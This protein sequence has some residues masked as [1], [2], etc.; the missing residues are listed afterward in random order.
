MSIGDFFRV[1][2]R[3]WKDQAQTVRYFY[4]NPRFAWVDLCLGAISLFSNPYRTCRKFLEKKGEIDTYA[5]GETPL[6]TLRQI[7]ENCRLSPSDHWMELGAGRAKGCFWIAA[8]FGC[9]TT[10]VE[11]VPRFVGTARLLQRFFRFP[12]LAF[13]LKNIEEADFASVTAVY[14]YGTCLSEETLARVVQNMQR[15][16]NGARVVAVSEPLQ[17]P[18]LTLK[19]VFP[20]RY[21]WGETDAFLLEKTSP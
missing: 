21:P 17:A 9:R 5:Y 11:W 3:I 1:K 6:T 10:G 7:A 8:F 13:E 14:L 20:V 4:K 15:L 12:R 16:P 19:R 2:T 18:F